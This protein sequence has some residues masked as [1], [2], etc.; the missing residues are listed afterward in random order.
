MSEALEGEMSRMSV[1]QSASCVPMKLLESELGSHEAAKRELS[2][3]AV[4][5]TRDLYNQR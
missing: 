1:V 5:T 4:N 3:R 2:K